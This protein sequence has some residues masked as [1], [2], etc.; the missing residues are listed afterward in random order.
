QIALSVEVRKAIAPLRPRAA[1]LAVP[2][3]GKIALGWDG[4]SGL[5]DVTPP[6]DRDLRLVV[7]GGVTWIEARGAA[8]RIAEVRARDRIT[9]AEAIARIAVGATLGTPPVAR[10]TESGAGALASGDFNGDGRADLVIGH[11]ERAKIG[12]DAGGLL[13]FYGDARGAL[14]ASA[15]MVIEGEH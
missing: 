4:G 9:R 11:A 12:G 5:V 8:P 14:A 6:E 1:I 3:G 13:V 2:A 7:E 15:D 10:G